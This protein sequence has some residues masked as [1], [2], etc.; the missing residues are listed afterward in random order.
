MVN[1][2]CA[3]HHRSDDD[4][5]NVY[6]SLLIDAFNRFAEANGGKP[7]NGMLLY[8]VGTSDS[9]IDKRRQHAQEMQSFV[10]EYYE[11]KEWQV[12]PQMEFVQI[13]LSAAK[14]FDAAGRDNAPPGSMMD[15]STDETM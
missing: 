8:L 5:E 9:R 12:K 13:N 3:F 1:V 4:G 15:I 10:N 6:R 11:S 7:P 14:L 2:Q